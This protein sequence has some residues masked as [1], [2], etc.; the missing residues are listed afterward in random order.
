MPRVH[1]EIEED[2]PL[3]NRG[4]YGVTNCKDS[5]YNCL[6][7]AVG[8]ITQ[9][10]ETGRKTRGYYWP[11]GIGQNDEIDEWAEIFAL[12]AYEPCETTRYEHGFEKV[13]ICATGQAANHVARQL[14]D[15]NWTSKLGD[16]AGIEHATT[17][18]LEGDLY[19]KVERVLKRRRPDWGQ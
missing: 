7:W 15:G 9:K 14:R 6:S 10:W 17:D 13:A 1:D 3:L 12:F 16:G 18:V 8:D 2:F 4:N 5:R 19:G 11:L